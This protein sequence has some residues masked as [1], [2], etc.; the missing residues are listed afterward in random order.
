MARF[1]G[2]REDERGWEREMAKR[3]PDWVD[4]IVWKTR[5][6]AG[7]LF[8]HL[9]GVLRYAVSAERFAD[10]VAWG[11]HGIGLAIP[12]GIMVQL[13][14]GQRRRLDALRAEIEEA[15]RWCSAAIDTATGRL[16]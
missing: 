16:K 15:T 7:I 10:Q 13:T 12:P 4:E 11:L 5:L 14:A 8:G 1:T 2:Q 9:G 6:A 3:K